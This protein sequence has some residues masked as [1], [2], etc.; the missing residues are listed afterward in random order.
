MKLILNFCSVAALPE[1]S[2][3][4]QLDVSDCRKV[5]GVTSVDSERLFVLHLPSKQQIAVY[6]AK[7]FTLQQTL[8]VSELRDYMSNSMTS[9]V[10]NNCIYVGDFYEKCVYKVE[11]AGN[12]RVLGWR[13]N[14][15]VG[16]LSVNSECNLLVSCSFAA[17]LEEYTPS[18]ELVRVIN[19]RWRSLNAIQ[20]SS[21]QFL[22]LLDGGD[23]Q[24]LATVDSRGKIVTSYESQLQSTI[25]RSL[26][27]PYQMTVDE[28][29]GCIFVADNGNNRI[30][31]FSRSLKRAREFSLSIDGLK[32]KTRCCLHFDNSTGR[33]FVGEAAEGG[34][35]F[36]F[37]IGR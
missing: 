22:C 29:N 31:I 24:E 32:L 28:N 10:T 21:D 25:I 5:I 4:V 11:L 9:C 16:G 17:K 30:V 7:T 13:S 19:L 14:G 35:L 36:V 15:G 37:A 2:N 27:N 6:D 33:L 20:L 23:W 3:V 1:L 8:S 12:N 18:G 34:R 26:K